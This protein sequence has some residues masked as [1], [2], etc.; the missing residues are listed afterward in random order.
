M[1]LVL[2]QVA[3]ITIRGTDVRTALDCPMRQS[4]SSRVRLFDGVTSVISNLPNSSLSHFS[5]WTVPQFERYWNQCEQ[6]G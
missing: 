5:G 4:G 6:C 1:H 2:L 3:G